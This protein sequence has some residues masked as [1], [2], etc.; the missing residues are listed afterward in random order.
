MKYKEDILREEYIESVGQSQ[1]E[2][3][4]SYDSFDKEH[5]KL[6]FDC[7]KY[8]IPAMYWSAGNKLN[9]EIFVGKKY[10]VIYS[11]NRNYFNGIATQQLIIKDIE[12]S[13]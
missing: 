7:G 1:E 4:K 13:N 11:M 8:K 10:N 3:E 2:G 9:S 12:L 6:V 5:L